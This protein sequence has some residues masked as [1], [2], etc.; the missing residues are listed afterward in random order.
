M[1]TDKKDTIYIDIDD[2]ITSI[3]DKVQSSPQKIVALVL[4]KRASMLQSSV[5]MRLLKRTADETKKHVVLITS[6]IGLLPLAGAVG[7]HVAKTLQSK[8]TIPPPPDVDTSPVTVHTDTLDDEP[9]IDQHKPV[10]ELAGLTADDEETIEVDNDE[11]PA[12]EEN[13]GK[14]RGKDEEKP[15]KKL[16]VPN[17]ERFRLRLFIIFGVV[18]VVIV[19]LIFANRVLPSATITIKTDATTLT[20]EVSLTADPNT[21]QLDV[22]GKI[23]PATVQ[24]SQ[25]SDSSQVSATGKKDKGTKATGS[26]TL[27][28][29]C[30]AKAPTI[31]SGTVISSNGL[32]FVTEGDIALT[33]PSIDGNGNC[34]F[35]GSGNVVAQSPGDQYNLSERDYNVSGLSAVSA[36]GSDMTGGTSKLITVVSQ[37]DVDNAKKK[38]VEAGKAAAIETL[39]KQLTN[40]NLLPLP[41]TFIATTANV[42]TSPQVGAES[43]TT[44]VSV[45]LMFTMMGIK[46]DDVKQLIQNDIKP[47]IDPEKQ[48]ILQDG[49]DKA[50]IRTANQGRDTKKVDI[51][52]QVLVG[53]QLDADSI[54][55]DIKGRKKG[56]AKNVILQRPGIKEVTVHYNPFWVVKAPSNPSKINVTFLQSNGQPAQK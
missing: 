17:F 46:Q 26:V 30:S 16:K 27:A 4:P 22:E 53:P 12:E 44:T 49:L 3:I 54:K 8:P 5:N 19:G 34:I 36:R 35:S 47:R 14:R 29:A 38:M 51:Q 48:I 32:N 11:V 31:S 23:V 41:D 33:T 55:Q 15:N 9:A 40:N 52:T 18:I 13:T 21:D 43:N 25:K 45:N 20:S 28:T 1:S 56:D 42:T 6:E 39:K 7:L 24:Q 50:V 10:G 2:E 37:S